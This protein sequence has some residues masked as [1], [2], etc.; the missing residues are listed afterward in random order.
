MF[1]GFVVVVAVVVVTE[2]N[3]PSSYELITYTHTHICIHTRAHK[4]G[5]LGLGGKR[6]RLAMSDP[7]SCRPT[8]TSVTC[9]LLALE[10]VQSCSLTYFRVHL[11]SVKYQEEEEE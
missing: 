3:N 2:P 7:P 10:S 8:V 1:W 4:T 11:R 6:A 9:P 5:F